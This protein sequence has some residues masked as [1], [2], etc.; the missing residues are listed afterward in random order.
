LQRLNKMAKK[1]I[2]KGLVIDENE[3]LVDTT[4]VGDESCY[5]VDDAG[6]QRH[7]PSEYVDKQ[8]LEHIAGMIEGHEDLLVEQAAKM[9][10]Q[11]DIFSRAML[12]KQFKDM[13]KQFE[14]ILETGIPEDGIAYM[15]M[16]G[17]RIKINMHGDII[18]IE[19]PGMIGPDDE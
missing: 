4:M 13:D 18:N 12:E 2:F 8:V 17:F 5:V 10:Q 15:G 16:T 11:D 7:I 6:F 19:Q 14:R 3:N 9:L 1:P